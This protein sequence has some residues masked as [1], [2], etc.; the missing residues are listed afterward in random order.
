MRVKKI[1]AALLLGA[2]LLINGFVLA[3][4]EEVKEPQILSRSRGCV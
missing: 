1:V 3:T 4:T 2:I